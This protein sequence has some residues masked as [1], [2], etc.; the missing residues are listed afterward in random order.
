[1]VL[2]LG[3][4]HVFRFTGFVRITQFRDVF[5]NGY[6]GCFLRYGKDFKACSP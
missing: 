1:M 2:V 6:T 5:K 3:R 4:V